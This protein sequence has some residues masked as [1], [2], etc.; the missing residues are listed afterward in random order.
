M[1]KKHAGKVAI[2]TGAASGMGQDVAVLLAELGAAIALVDRDAEGLQA[3]SGLL[4]DLEVPTQTYV[5]DL[6]ELKGLERLVGTIADDFGHIDI[7]MNAAG[8]GR[9]K[10]S[11]LDFDLAEW[12]RLHAI[13][14]TA[15]TM[16]LSYTARHMVERRIEGRIVNYL[17]VAAF[18]PSTTLAYGSAKAAL[19]HVTR[20]AAQQLGPHGINVNAVVP[21]LTMTNFG[22]KQRSR[23]EA[24]ALAS[25]GRL[26]NMKGKAAVAR[27]VNGPAVFLTLPEASH[28]TGHALH[29]NAGAWF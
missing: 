1:E 17:S 18:R 29:T 25:S 6:E 23:Q 8:L 15:P 28:I 22:A 11:V 24:D 14:H 7:L 4:E 5:H 12:S 19:T 21:G 9:E 20:I 26:A 16:L 3:T 2:V 27:D 13:N 10:E